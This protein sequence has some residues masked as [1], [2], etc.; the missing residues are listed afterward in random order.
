MDSDTNFI[1]FSKSEDCA[2]MLANSSTKMVVSRARC[3][4]EGIHALDYWR[5]CRQ[6]VHQIVEQQ[7]TIELAGGFLGRSCRGGD[8]A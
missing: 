1:G 5:V 4:L 6:G 2:M 3:R 7:Q 8:E